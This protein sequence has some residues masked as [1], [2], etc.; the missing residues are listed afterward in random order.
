MNRPCTLLPYVIWSL[1]VIS[2]LAGCGGSTNVSDNLC[3]P[4]DIVTAPES[5]IESTTN[6]WPAGLPVDTKQP[7]E[8]VDAAGKV[9][10]A[11][12][13]TGSL[14]A[15]SIINADSIYSPGVER[16]GESAAGVSDNGEAARLVSGE[17]QADGLSWVYYRLE[18]GGIQPGA[19]SCDVNLLPM[20]D[21]A[22]SSYY[23][24]LSNYGDSVWQWQ[25]PFAGNHTRLSLGAEVAAGADYLS[26][27]GNLYVCLVACNGATFDVVCA[28]ANPISAG[29]STAPDQPAGLT[30]AQMGGGL[31]L[32]WDDVD[33]ADLAGYRIYYAPTPFADAGTAGVTAL[34]G[35]IGTT[36]Y[37]LPAAATT[38]VRISA[39]DINGNE[40]ALSEQVSG[41][42]QTGTPPDIRLSVDTPS[43]MIGDPIELT[44]S[45]AEVYDWDLDGDGAFDIFADV[46]GTQLVDT[47]VYGL[48]RPAVQGISDGT[49]LAGCGVS[50]MVGNNCRPL[51]N[52]IAT[53][54]SGPAVLNVTLT[55]T[56][57]DEDGEIVLYAWDF[58]GDG[59]YDYSDAAEPNPPAQTY[60]TPGVYNVKFRVEDDLGLTD[61]DTVTVLVE[62]PLNFEPAADV[63]IGTGEER[64]NPPQL[65]HF[66]ASGSL[67]ID[68][69]I[70]EYVW[71]FDGDGD[72][73]EW[74]DGPLVE[75]TYTT[76]GDFTAEVRVED[77][78]GARNSATVD[79]SLNVAPAADL[80][81]DV[82]SGDAPLT[83][84]FDASGSSDID[85]TIVDYEWDLD[86]D[87]TFNETGAEADARSNATASYSYT[88]V[89]YFYPAVRVTDNEGLT[90]TA[91]L[92]IMA[93]G[94][95]CF[96][97]DDST[98]AGRGWN[99]L[100]VVNGRPAI[101][102]VYYQSSLHYIR[103]STTTG[104]NQADWSNSVTLAGGEMDYLS[105]TVIDGNPAI[106]FYN[107]SNKQLNY[108]RASTSTGDS[109]SA[110]PGPV[111]VDPETQTG[112]YSSL[113]VVDGNPAISYNYTH[114]SPYDSDLRYARSSTSTG[115]S[116]SDWS[117]VTVDNLGNTGSFISLA[118]VDGCPAIAYRYDDSLDLKYA[119][120]TTSTG[121]NATDW[122]LITTVDTTG[123]SGF[124]NHLLVVA[125]N[126]AISYFE[127][128]G[129]DLK[130]VRAGNST[131]SVWNSPVTIEFE[132]VSGTYN[133][134]AIVNG[135]PAISYQSA[136]ADLNYVRSDTA[137]GGSSDW[138]QCTTVDSDGITGYYSS[139]T[140]VG[141]SPAIAYYNLADDCLMYAYYM[142]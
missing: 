103:A 30:S 83:V 85:G 139:L 112:A 68:G 86:C 82:T 129:K 117:V 21:T 80:D 66:D 54:A 47:S 13:D 75:H 72:Y 23:I 35:L 99:N 41:A 39:V 105:M 51:A 22:Q 61:V 113:A 115:T 108:M 87:G 62:N 119:R 132:G 71:D 12:S 7:W 33:A 118:V 92:T 18:L 34:P 98:G 20:S 125:G 5:S 131:G 11:A 36:Y 114:S 42:P 15:G 127:N 14:K 89:G 24:G 142:Q 138:T 110:W 140:V 106:S 79:V 73:D 40:S 95:V 6:T 37:V 97:V 120:A 17:A 77:D 31:A 123:M 109:A 53:P 76:S 58:D 84:N 135:N 38:Y 91:S 111:V 65:V 10:I 116:A 122:T 90:D 60:P 94:W 102:Y 136:D 48:I 137:T 43:G 29:D 134:M 67:D 4:D 52:G 59:T 126:P 124:N 55:G 8:Q 45:G 64:G 96:P 100:A 133:S 57:A 44:A 16:D 70:E 141:N 107:C 49:C 101:A 78:Q 25:G 26:P 63:E 46:T 27:L 19:A 2:A 74:S 121:S 104:S 128:Q 3:V 88:G 81:A 32:A 1:L 9:V 28:A 130:F 56:G 69:T 50:V 93:K